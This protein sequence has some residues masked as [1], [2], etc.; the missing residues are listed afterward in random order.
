MIL[1]SSI[2]VSAAPKGSRKDFT[3]NET[4]FQM[5]ARINPERS[6]LLQEMAAG[7]GRVDDRAG[8]R[9]EGGRRLAGI[10][11][12][13]ARTRGLGEGPPSLPNLALANP[14]NRH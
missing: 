2:V 5:L 3:A 9:C 6:A 14:G 8:P 12:A 1:P 13:A 7:E 11:A 4:R 10:P